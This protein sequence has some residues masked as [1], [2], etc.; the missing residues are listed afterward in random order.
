M[1]AEPNKPCQIKRDYPQLINLYPA[2]ADTDAHYLSKLSIY[3]Q[4][5][6]EAHS[7]Q[8]IL[9]LGQISL[10]NGLELLSWWRAHSH[11][12]QRL[13]LKVFEPNPINAYEL[14]LLWDQSA[15]LTKEPELEPLAQRLLHAEPAAIIGC[16][17]LIFDDG[18]FTIDLHFGDIQSQLSSLIHSPLH[19]VQHW[20]VLPHLQ[21]GLN[22]QNHWQMAKLSDDSAT[23]ATI[24]SSESSGLN[25]T[26]IN[27]F[28]AC[29]FEMRDFTCTE[30]QTN[31]QPDAILLHE[32]HVLRQQDAKAYAF[33]PMAAILPSNTSSS[34]AIIGGGLASAHLALS[35][36]E[37]GQGTQLFCKDAKL[38]QGASGNRQ[39]AIYPLLTPEND[40][41]SRFFQQAFL[42]SRRRVQALTSAP[43][44]NQTSIS[45]DF[46]GVLQTAHDERSQLRLDK[47]IQG[48]AWPSEI[49]YRV[50]TQQANSLANINIDKSG[51]FY[52]LGGWVCPFEYA[53][54]AIQ[55]AMQLADVSVSLN[56]D[57]L[58]IEGQSDGW[59]LL[60]EKE[61]LGPFAQLVLA[62]GAELTQ[63]DAS[64][65]LQISPF[66]GQVSHVPAQ[67]QLSQL[68]T[69]LCA[70]GYL[71]PSHQGL[72]CLG[73]SYVKEPRH[74]DFCPQEQQEN[75]AKM[76]ESY[77]KQSWLKDIDMSGNN[78]RVGV[79]MVTRDHFPMMGCAPDVAKILE[80]YEQHQ[81][82]KE[83]RHFWQTT[84]APVHQGLYILGGLGSRGLS[85]GPLAAECLAAQ[86]CGE[87]IP[88]DKATLCKLNP[89]RMWL[90]KLLK[91]KSL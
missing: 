50:D 16:Q 66:R 28:Q 33:N 1:T 49:A 55:K 24:E 76:H 21:N 85:S 12:S 47:I 32:R 68:A 87:P 88:L 79:R 37:R 67:F 71:T 69:V 74:L 89:N 7:Q 22:Q 35:L 80:D 41:L 4:R 61:R 43:A 53:E 90:R 19:P 73:A 54:A 9:V 38:G 10:G 58:A 17:R 15:C 84:L 31:H 48:Q 34:I 62:N 39:G 36:A 25:E 6:F 59:V 91:G 81:L 40:E 14:K 72:H 42:F 75:L 23:I 57:I 83:S 60:T 20:L 18:R 13:L 3:Q 5:V 44:P 78:A 86:L 46:C 26:T 2:T 11:L 56:T 77:P 64:N 63:F 51:F 70:N 45:H 27:R 82:T 65:K 52:P 30:I 8:K 29:G